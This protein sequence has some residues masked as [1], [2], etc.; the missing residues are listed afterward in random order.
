MRNMK[1]VLPRYGA[2]TARE[3]NMTAAVGREKRENR[4]PVPS[5]NMSSPTSDSAV[6]T[7]CAAIPLGVTLP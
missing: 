3:L 1:A 5:A 2:I 4:M 6:I 7:K